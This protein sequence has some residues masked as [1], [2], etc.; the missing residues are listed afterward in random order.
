MNIR[1]I[2]PGPLAPVSRGSNA[3]VGSGLNAGKKQEYATQNA[4]HTID[5]PRSQGGA[6]SPDNYLSGGG[7][8]RMSG[9]SLGSALPDLQKIN[10]N[11]VKGANNSQTIDNSSNGKL[12]NAWKV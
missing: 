1:K 10:L 9:V 3:G 8:S 5:V 6:A 7:Q 12:R 11:R 4:S 2:N